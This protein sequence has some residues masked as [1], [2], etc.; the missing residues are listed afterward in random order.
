MYVYVGVGGAG[1]GSEWPVKY[2]LSCLKVQKDW[3]AWVAQSVRHLTL[4]QVVISQ[5]MGSSPVSGS[6]LTA[7]ILE[8][9]SDS[10]SPSLSAPL[11]FSL[12]LSKRNKNKKLFFTG[13]KGLFWDGNVYRST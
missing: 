11:L 7:Q 4:A 8:P 2:S 12:S 6:V 13:S 5:F 3:G 9:A 1:H 10:V